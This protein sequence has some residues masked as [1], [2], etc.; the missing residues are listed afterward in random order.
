MIFNAMLC[1]PSE[2][3][4][5]GESIYE[6]KIDGGRACVKIKNNKVRIEGRSGNNWTHKFP[7]IVEE[8]KD[9]N[10]CILDGEIAV[11]DNG[12]CNFSKFQKRVQT[13]NETI[14][15]IRAKT[16]PATIFIFDILE[17][18]GDDLRDCKLIER[19]KILRDFI[20][21]T[22]H[23]HLLEYYSTPDFLL[24]ISHKIEGIVQKNIYSKYLEGIRSWSWIK[25]KFK[26]EIEAEVIDF[27]IQPRGVTLILKNNQRVV[28]NGNNVKEKVE[29]LMK[30]GCFKVLIE[31]HSI[32]KSGK[33]REPVFKKVIQ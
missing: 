25:Y 9:Y 15:N 13:D 30:K 20:K 28:W 19:K 24:T 14:I 2:I 21:N 23:V 12:S 32:T 8:L 26:K 33:M 6:E 18:N 4:C 11:R 17:R 29:N 10:D 22:N 27:E 31:C 16:I 1:Q 5:N 7:Y 3:K